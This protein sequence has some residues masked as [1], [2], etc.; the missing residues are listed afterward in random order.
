MSSREKTNEFIT[1]KG[2]W[3][4]KQMDPI[5]FSHVYLRIMM[6]TRSLWKKRIVKSTGRNTIMSVS[7]LSPAFIVEISSLKA[8]IIIFTILW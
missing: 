3:N 4:C 6:T 2:S 1:Q 7:F 5:Q 8:L